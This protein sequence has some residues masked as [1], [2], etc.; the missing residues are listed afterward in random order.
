MRTLFEIIESAKD[1]Y[2]PTHEECYWAML[3]F[4]SML[5][6]DHNNYFNELMNNKPTPD[7]I[8]KN[9]ARNS[10][11]MYHNALNVSPKDWLGSFGDPSNSEYQRFRTVSKKVWDNIV[12]KQHIDKKEKN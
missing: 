6:I 9:K 4:S 1:G 8:K 7:F 5:N 10:H 2:M 11:L 12:V 3:A